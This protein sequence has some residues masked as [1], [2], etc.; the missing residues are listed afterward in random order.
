MAKKLFKHI[1]VNEKTGTKAYYY[2]MPVENTP[3]NQAFISSMRALGY[4][5]GWTKFGCETIH[6]ALIPCMKHFKGKNGRTVYIDTPESEQRFIYNS[7]IRE[8]MAEQDQTKHDGRCWFFIEHGQRVRCP[9]RVA[10]PNYDPSLPDDPKSNPKTIRNCCETCKYYPFKNTH[11]VASFSSLVV[12]DDNGEVAPYEPPTPW[13][14]N[15]PDRYNELVSEVKVI[16][17]K[18]K[19]KLDSLVDLLAA[20]LTQAEAA[21]VLGKKT[22]TINSQCKLLRHLLDIVPELQDLLLTK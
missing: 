4:E 9:Y 11:D 16:L 21:N 20:E 7:Y 8:A 14:Y 2:P 12:E 6:A 18:Y 19:P 15:E 1:Q 5:V 17:H 22:T 13:D 3:E 10:N